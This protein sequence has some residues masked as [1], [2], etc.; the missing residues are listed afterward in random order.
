MRNRL[1]PKAIHQLCPNAVFNWSQDVGIWLWESVD[2]QPTEAQIQAKIA[3][4]Q[5]AE[6]LR[7]LREQRNQLLAQSDWRMVADYPGTNQTEWQT[8]RQA[9]RDITTQTPSLDADGNL[10]GITWPT[11]PND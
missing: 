10:T 3:E 9:L 8:Y 4:L 5:A 7:L 11:P 6:P 2:S 1:E